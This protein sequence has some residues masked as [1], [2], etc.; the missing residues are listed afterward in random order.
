[1]HRFSGREQDGTSPPI[2]IGSCSSSTAQRIRK[3]RALPRATAFAF[4]SLQ[5]MVVDGRFCED[6]YYRI[7][8]FPIHLPPLRERG[9]DIPL[10]V[11][12]FLKT[13]HSTQEKKRSTRRP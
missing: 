4:Q 13:V 8:V 3:S 5:Q 12:S 7:S 10:L 6:L 2:S 11:E 9:G 1:M